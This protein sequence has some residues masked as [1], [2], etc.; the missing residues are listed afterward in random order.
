MRRRR[1]QIKI[2]LLHILPMIAFVPV[3][4]KQP[5]LQNGV[6]PIPHRQTKTNHLMAIADAPNS[7]FAP[8]IS[9]RTRMIVRKIFPRRAARAVVLAH[10][11]PLPLG[12]IR[13]PALPILLAITRLFQSFVFDGLYSWHELLDCRSPQNATTYLAI[14]GRPEPH[15]VVLPFMACYAL[16]VRR[17]K[18]PPVAPQAL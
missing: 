3:Q 12:K 11:S 7:V 17:L 16:P 4:A 14:F 5:F 6:A 18:A 8:S 13:P 2:L 15:G 1:I 9:S 10:R